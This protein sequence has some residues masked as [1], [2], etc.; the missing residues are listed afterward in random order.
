MKI[1]FYI[2]ALI[3]GGAERV[4]VL[5]CNE[6]VKRGH[7]VAVATNPSKGSYPINERVRLL[8]LYSEKYKHLPKGVRQLSVI[9]NARRIVKAEK[10]N[11]VIGVMPLFYLLARLVTWGIDSPLIASDHTSFL[12]NKLMRVNFIRHHLYGFADVLTILTKKDFQL[13]GNKYPKKIVMYNPLTFDVLHQIG[14]RKK[15]VT[16]MGRLD[17]WRVKGFDLLIEAWAMI[18]SKHPDWILQIAGTGSDESMDILKKQ[19]E[20]RGILDSVRFLGFVNNVQDLLQESAVFVLSSR[21]EGF[22]MS[23]LEAMSQG[24]T[25]VAF[26]IQGVVNEIISHGKDGLVVPDGDIEMLSLSLERVLVN[27]EIRIQLGCN[28]LKSI[29]RFEAENIAKQWEALFEKLCK[30]E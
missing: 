16:A 23:L 2:P 13:L 30:H 19:I 17:V 1:L 20:D 27:E 29:K 3:G 4:T 5:L 12:P 26:A 11:V 15:V 28:A 6:F 7:D 9:R 21:I 18:A 8:S 22:P 14:E 25:C 10:P 24:C